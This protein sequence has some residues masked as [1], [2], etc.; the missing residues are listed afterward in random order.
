MATIKSIAEAIALQPILRVKKSDNIR[1][2][3]GENTNVLN[4][5]GSND[6]AYGT[7]AILLYTYLH[8]HAYTYNNVDIVSL[9]KEEDYIYFPRLVKAG[10][11]I[12]II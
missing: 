3:N 6:T 12:A 11:K 9:I 5:G 10:L 8:A 2:K 1:T 7:S 4:N